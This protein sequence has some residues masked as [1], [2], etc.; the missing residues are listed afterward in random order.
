MTTVDMNA[1]L[2]Q[3]WFTENQVGDIIFTVG[4]LDTGHVDVAIQIADFGG[5][6]LARQVVIHGF[7]TSDSA[8]TTPHS[9]EAVAITPTTGVG[10]ILTQEATNNRY[11]TLLTDSTGLAN[12]RVTHT[13]DVYICIILP[14]G[15]YIVS[16]VLDLTA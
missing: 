8:G 4:A 13:S 5:E 15:R 10:T 6:A 16:D 2:Y 9:V 3:R 12:V 11:F 14:N 7:I 1:E